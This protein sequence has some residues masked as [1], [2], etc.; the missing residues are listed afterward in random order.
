MTPE[1]L[2]LMWELLDELHGMTEQAVRGGALM[3]GD[4]WA[5]DKTTGRFVI[6]A[7]YGAG[8][9]RLADKLGVKLP[10]PQVK[11]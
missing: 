8:A 5:Y 3:V 11:L 1:R 2:K 7:K 6:Y 9:V 4:C 10:M